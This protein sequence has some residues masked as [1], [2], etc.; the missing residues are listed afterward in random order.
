[1]AEKSR[2]RRRGKMWLY[3]LIGTVVGGLSDMT[4]FIEGLRKGESLGGL[5]GFLLGGMIVGAA[6][7]WVIGWIAGA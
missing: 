1:M 7:G 2:R 4:F 5:L 3:V 6:I